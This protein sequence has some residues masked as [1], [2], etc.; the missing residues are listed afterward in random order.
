MRQ[1]ERGGRVY[2]VG[3]GPGDPGLLTIRGRDLLEAADVVLADR[4]VVDEVLAMVPPEKLVDVGR[5]PAE[6]RSTRER[7]EAI[8]RRLVEL[9][10]EGK[11]VVR[12]KG[13]DPYVFGR[14]GEEVEALRDAGIPVEIVPGVTSA[15]AGPAAFGIP[16]THRDLAS[17]A[18]LV[19]GHEGLDK[20]GPDVD[21]EALARL[22]GTLV[23]L[24]GVSSLEEY[25][26]RLLGGGME[27]ETPVA[28]IER[29]TLPDQ[30]MVRGRLGEIVERARSAR[31]RPPAVVVIGPVVDLA[32]EEEGEA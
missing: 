22:D 25:V 6:G 5:V 10:R 30:R 17:V 13:G 27:A 16:L 31:V 8:S 28:V 24:M 1:P 12:L 9:A 21:W 2:L 23:V 7:Q 15:V 19:S 29:G 32:W 20:E 11:A 3:A 18:A 26:A 4:L 14:G